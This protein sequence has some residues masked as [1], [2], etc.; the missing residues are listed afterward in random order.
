MN[1]FEKIFEYIFINQS[2]KIIFYD[3]DKNRV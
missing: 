2:E 1:T 3:K